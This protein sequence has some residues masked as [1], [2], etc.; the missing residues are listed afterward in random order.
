MPREDL[1]EKYGW[2]FP[3]GSIYNTSSY[4]TNLR[5]SDVS[6]IVR[7]ARAVSTVHNRN[8]RTN[9]NGAQRNFGN[10]LDLTKDEIDRFNF[11]TGSK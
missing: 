1:D 11:V 6:G 8:V 5:S 4:V 9:Y 3:G 2:M 7:T 10:Y